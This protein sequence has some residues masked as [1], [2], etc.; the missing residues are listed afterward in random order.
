M[1]RLV[2]SVTTE[3]ALAAEQQVQVLVFLVLGA[4]RPT[5]DAAA[6]AAVAACHS[7]PATLR[8]LGAEMSSASGRRSCA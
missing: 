1:T 3:Q 5:R 8:A 4:E 6:T 2:Q 7:Q